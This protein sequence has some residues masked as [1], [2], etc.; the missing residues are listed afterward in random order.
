MDGGMRNIIVGTAGHVDHGKTT[1]IRALTGIDTDRLKEE[2]E[3]GMTIDLGFASLRLPNGES[4]GIVDV[5]GHERFIKNM[6]A[7]AGGVD[8][9]LLVVAADESVMPQTVEHL[10]ILQLLEVKRG[11]VALTKADMV[12]PDWLDAVRDDVHAA[13]EKTFLADSPIIPVSSTTGT[14]LAVL[15]SALQAACDEVVVRDASGPFRM[16]I[17]RVFTLTG[18]GTVVTGTLVSGTVHLGDAAEIVPSGLRSRIRQLQVHGRK[19][20]SCS[21]GTRV[22]MNLVG[23]EVAD[24][25]RGD[26][27]ATPGTVRASGVMDIH[28]SLLPNAAKPLKNR[29][30]I[31]LYL[32]TAELIGRITVLDREEIGPGE[33]AFVQ[34]RSESPVGVMRGDRFVVRSYSP[35]LTI[36]G[37]RVVEPC[38]RR[39]RRFD[40]ELI[41]ALEAG[42]RG[43]P[44][45]LVEQAV[46]ASLGGAS[47]ADVCKSVGLEDCG[48]SIE[49][50]KE[51]GRI[52][53]LENGRLIHAS[54]VMELESGIRDTLARFHDAN[55]LKP[56]M[57]KEEL[58]RTIGKALDARTF[59][60][61]L[62]RLA[63]GDEIEATEAIVRLKNR[64]P[65]FTPEEQAAVDRLLSGLDAAGINVPPASELLDGVSPAKGKEILEL[66]LHRGEIVK[67]AENLYFHARSLRSAED[68]VRRHLDEH[69]KITVA[70][71]RDLTQSSRKYALPILEYLDAKKVT[72]RVGDERVPFKQTC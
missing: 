5:P 39:H 34:F 27:C 64:A 22:A 20:E 9:A 66:L 55:R 7:G 8:V 33:D 47:S 63:K 71:F 21:A 37:G 46:R 40:S 70:E 52:L 59:T 25:A 17:D 4:A 1:L 32:G 10:E 2:K 31:R 43:T 62:S 58:R 54:A 29:A 49:L 45:E 24:V 42:S 51:N 23:L 53:E 44:E 50:L 30:R 19:V 3:R 28:V 13:L 12:E 26:V 41:S 14:G 67:V 48:R 68:A 18:F 38:A 15:L 65:A 11:I 35:M 60:E 72:R 36:G 6:L 16:P 56:G 61:L 57:S 69:G